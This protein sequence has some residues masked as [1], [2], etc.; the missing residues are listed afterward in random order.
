VYLITWFLSDFVK[1]RANK[2]QLVTKKRGR[3]ADRTE[4]QAK[5]EADL[6]TTAATS[7]EAVKL[8]VD[9]VLG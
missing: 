9:K 5:E 4:D 3:K 6:V 8:L 7:L 1:E 2:E